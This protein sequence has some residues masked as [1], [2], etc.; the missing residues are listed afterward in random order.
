VLNRRSRGVGTAQGE[1][2]PI[3][4]DCEDLQ[5]L[6]AHTGATRIFG[7]SYGGLVVL[8][9][10]KRSPEF[11]NIA[12][13]EPGVSIDN[14]IPTAW[15]PRYRQMLS[16]GDTRGAFAYFVQN[17]G[18]PPTF[19]EKMPLW[20]LKAVM[21][22]VI[23][24]AQWQRMEPLL[25]ANIIEHEQE[26]RFDNTVTSYGTITARVL[27]IGGSKSPSFI[28][29]PL[30]RLDDVLADSTVEILAGL[31]HNAPDERAP[32]AVGKCL[33]DFLTWA[34][35]LAPAPGLYSSLR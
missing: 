28:T 8:E 33:V 29:Q 7:H 9:T 30:H 13:Y 2:C 24:K 31:D 35:G 14:S 17:S 12:V 6:Q 3:E 27:L 22:L 23:R 26:I 18:H 16:A 34:P 1:T 32:Q 25:H 5:A 19:V 11:T 20:Y 4:R 10:A 21:R 15:I